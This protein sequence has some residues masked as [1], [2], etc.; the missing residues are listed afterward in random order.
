LKSA[1]GRE[2]E[3]NAKDESSIFINI[4]EKCRDGATKKDLI[5]TIPL[6]SNSNLQLRRSTAELVYRRLL[7]Y[8]RKQHIFVTTDR[9]ILF[10]S[11]AKKTSEIT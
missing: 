9:G 7:S 10:L 6:M 2:E 3:P 8:N 1:S 5:N 4:L 11:K